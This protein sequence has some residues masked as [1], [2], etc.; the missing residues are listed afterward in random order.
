MHAKELVDIN[1][2]TKTRRRRMRRR[3]LRVVIPVGCVLLMVATILSITTYGYYVNRRD[4][5]GLSDDLL[6][7]LDRRIATQVHDYLIPA[8]EMVGLAANIVQDPAFGI[9]KDSQIE[10]LAI[11]I[12]RTYPQLTAFSIA[13]YQRRF[14][15]AQKNA[16]WIHSHQTH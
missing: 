3:L 1:L 10:A 8:S 5:L 14:H 4:T 9:D 15:Y 12:L 6:K 13:A 16:R 2:D 11:Q 7:A